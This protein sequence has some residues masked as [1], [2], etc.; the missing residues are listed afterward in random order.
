MSGKEPK[1]EGSYEGTRR[2]NQATKEFVDSHDVQDL[3][4]RAKKDVEEDD[5]TLREAEKTGRKPARG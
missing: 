1:G 3:A 5:G 4:E 2:Y